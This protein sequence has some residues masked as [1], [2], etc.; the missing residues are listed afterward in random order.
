LELQIGD[1][2]VVPV[3]GVGIV[4]ANEEVDVGDGM[5]SAFRIDMGED[6]GTFWIPV[7]QLG[8]QG[9]RVPIAKEHLALLWTTL[10]EQVVPKNR[11]NWN[12]RRKRFDEMLASNE[13]L[14]LA[15][16]IGELMAVQADKR[17]RKQVL[18]FGERQLLD[19]TQDLLA[20]ELAVTLDRPVAD[21]RDEIGR[22]SPGNEG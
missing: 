4:D 16:L 18:S 3:M 9:L 5:V 22:R 10:S 8:S 7:A 11:E 1:T 14:Q 21:V 15:A 12:R 19:K 6:E 17:T 2:V 20:A 13:P